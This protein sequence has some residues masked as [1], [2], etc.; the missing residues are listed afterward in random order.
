MEFKKFSK[1]LFCGALAASMAVISLTACVSEADFK[2][3]EKRVA[4]LEQQLE[5]E[6]SSSASENQSRATSS[7][8]ET[9]SPNETTSPKES[10]DKN[11]A[12]FDA[13]EISDDINVE[14]HDFIDDDGNKFSFFVF[15]NKSDF[16]VTAK[17]KIVCKDKDGKELEDSE[18]I[19]EGIPKGKT[20]F[21]SFAVDK[22]TET[23]VRTVTYE[24]YD[25]KINPL[26]SVSA[27][28]SKAQG[29]ANI[30]VTNTGSNAAKDLKYL[31]LFFKGNDFVGFD[32]EKL[33][34]L[35]ASSNESVS[36]V[37]YE[38]FDTVEVYLSIDD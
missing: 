18:E 35:A 5:S 29:G 28:S 25:E 31:A 13:D 19:V 26:S 32:S 10:P 12:D 33:P 23:I 24:E 7:P 30:A 22:D 36:A 15:S 34:D 6:G 38:D 4:S 16:D 1:K 20:S 8:K 14:E 37:C 27:K 21:A 2:K 9:S 11:D 17:I 3:L